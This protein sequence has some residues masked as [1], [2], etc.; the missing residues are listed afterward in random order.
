[1]KS[2]FGKHWSEHIRERICP[3]FKQFGELVLSRV[4]P[5]FE[6]INEEAHA[7]E[8]R[9]YDELMSHVSAPEEDMWEAGEAMADL[10]FNEAMDHAVL[11]ESMRYATINLYAAALYHLT[12]QH[13]IDLVLQIHNNDEQHNHRPEEAIAW[14]KNALGLDLSTLSS[15]PVLEELRLVANVVKHGEG[16]S[17]GRL[18]KIRPAD[19][20]RAR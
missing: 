15:W 3:R 5:A 13:L 10:A 7:L 2:F 6:G 1:M 11:L 20:A 8:R 17:A 12:E 14:F 16:G 9:R 4:L 18:R 19:L